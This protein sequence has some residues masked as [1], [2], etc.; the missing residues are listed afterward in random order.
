MTVKEVINKCELC[1]F[2]VIK[3]KHGE[4]ILNTNYFDDIDN[5]ILNKEVKEYHDYL[6]SY[7]SEDYDGNEFM[8]CEH[9]IL[10]VI[11]Y[12]WRVN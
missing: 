2:L 10:E 7:T 5:N 4:T 8:V 12:V 6:N 1:D 9:S 3:N 11:L